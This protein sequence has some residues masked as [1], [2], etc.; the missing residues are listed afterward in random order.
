MVIGLMWQVVKIFVLCNIHLKKHPE[1]IH[2]LNPGEQF[3][4]LV[5]LSPEQLLLRWLNYHPNSAGYDKKIT[6]FS[7][8]IKD[9]EKY[10]IF[11][12]Q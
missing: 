4:D 6:N 9:S 5:K 1:L 10:T 2:L 8:D 3:A 11:L 12:N 7:G